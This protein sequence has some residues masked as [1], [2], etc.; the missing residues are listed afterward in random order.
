M[1]HCL[2]REFSTQHGDFSMG[3][4]FCGVLS[5][6]L[7]GGDAFLLDYGLFSGFGSADLRGTT[8]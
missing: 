8:L 6:T 2:L 3:R 5:L 4:R 1:E 7:R